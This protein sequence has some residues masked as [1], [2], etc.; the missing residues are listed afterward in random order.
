M[1]RPSWDNTFKDILSVFVKR[2]RCIK[3]KT[4]AMVV[5]GSQIMSFGYN[6]TFAKCKECDEYWHQYHT[7]KRISVPFEEWTETKEF[8]DLHREWSK[9]NEI[10]AE[11]NAL[12]WISKRDINDDYILYTIYSP[13]DACAKEIISYGIK[14]IKYIAEYPNGSDALARL[15]TAGVECKKIE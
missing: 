8:R 7:K 12:N 4:A 5:N 3:Y 2:S 10:H 11:V 9:S 14:H 15:I 1:S 13:C 6:G